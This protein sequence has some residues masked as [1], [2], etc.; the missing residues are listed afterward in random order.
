MSLIMT[1]FIIY[2][3]LTLVFFLA[4]IIDPYT[5]YEDFF[6]RDITVSRLLL[7]ACM[8]GLLIGLVFKKKCLPSIKRM[9][10]YKPFKQDK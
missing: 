1:L 9:S 8:H 7:L 5:K 10:N 2:I 6:T 4:T 3:T